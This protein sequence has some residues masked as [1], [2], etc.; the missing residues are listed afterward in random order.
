MHTDTRHSPGLSLPPTVTS[1][2]LNKLVDQRNK[3]FEEAV[4]E[5]ALHT[6]FFLVL[7]EKYRLIEATPE[8]EVSMDLLQAAAR[9]HIPVNPSAKKALAATSV[10][11]SQNMIIPEP[12]DRLSIDGVIFELQEQAWYRNQIVDRRTFEA[13]EP[14]EGSAVLHGYFLCLTSCMR[15]AG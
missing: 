12:E 15:I 1:A 6:L 7:T 4:N 3:R 5:Y 2:Q 14:V 11:D 10:G 9:D 8:G 13:K